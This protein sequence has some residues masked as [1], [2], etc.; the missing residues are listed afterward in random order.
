VVGGAGYIGSHMVIDLLFNNYEVIVLDDFSTGN[1]DLVPACSLVEGSLGD[2]NLLDKIFSGQKVFAVMHFAAHSL[3][4]ESVEYPLKYYENNVARTITLLNSMIRYDIKYFIFSSSAAVYGEPLHVPIKESHAC[5][6]TNPYGSTKLAVEKILQYCDDAYGLRYVSLRY[7][8]AAGAHM[9][10]KIGERHQPETH[11]IPLILKV[12]LGE[13][14]N[15]RIFGTN[16]PTVDG[17]CI[18]DY[19]HVNDLTSAHLLALEALLN[20]MESAAYNLGN[21]KGY[22]VREV[23]RAV[24]RVTNSS[25]PFEETQRRPGDP[26]VLVAGSEKIKRELGWKPHFEELDAIVG[27]A[28][29]WH[30]NDFSKR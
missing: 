1:R 16:Y 30:K 3:V 7:F 11:L 27:T 20:G 10:G 29:K 4:G 6:P 25:I 22:S 23:I 8:N 26:A 5:N 9:S 18:R 2:H 14:R 21:S 19:I 24:E 17:T 13:S 28:W 15:I 12:A